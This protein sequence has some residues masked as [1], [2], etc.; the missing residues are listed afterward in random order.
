MDRTERR[1]L[2]DT[3]MFVGFVLGVQFGVGATLLVIE[4]LK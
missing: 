1:S 4:L 2:V 3:S